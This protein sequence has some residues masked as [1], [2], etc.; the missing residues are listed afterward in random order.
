[1]S[2]TIEAFPQKVFED[3][4]EYRAYLKIKKK[5]QTRLKSKENTTIRTIKVSKVIKKEL[6]EKYEAMYQCLLKL[7][8]RYGY[9]I[10]P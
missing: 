5:V 2:F 3:F 7:Q 8:Q 9:I 1:M 6:K 4:E 10:P